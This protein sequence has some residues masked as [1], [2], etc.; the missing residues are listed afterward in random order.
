MTLR[1]SSKPP[2]TIHEYIQRLSNDTSISLSQK[3]DCLKTLTVVLKNLIDANKGGIPGDEGLKYRTLKLDNPKVKARL[4]PSSSASQVVMDF[5]M[6]STHV[7]MKPKRRL[8]R[9]LDINLLVM[10]TVPSPAMQEHIRGHVLPA[11]T[12]TQADINSKMLAAEEENKSHKK[13]KLL[14]AEHNSVSNT[15]PTPA[16]P[17]VEKLSEKQL[18]RRELEKK[19][20]L[21]KEQD[22]Q[23]RL[24]TKAQLAADKLVRETDENWK[25]AVSAAADK[26]GTGIQTFRDRHGE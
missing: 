9:D 5:L 21:E 26:T 10:E 22:K 14:L 19:K 11:L 7:G 25:P 24:K 18:A 13:A 12:T 4:F 6:D 8:K 1:L 17:P 23:H 16:A 15:K 20:Q 3:N 2:L